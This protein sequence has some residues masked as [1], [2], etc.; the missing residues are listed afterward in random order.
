MKKRDKIFIAGHKGMVGSAIF[1]LLDK[2]GYR[3]II[4]RTRDKLDLLNQ[5]DVQNFF[6]HIKPKFVFV[7]AARVGGLDLG[8]VPGKKG[9]NLEGILHA[10][11]IGKIDAIYLLGADEI[12]MTKLKD[13]FV[14]YQGHH[15][16]I[17]AHHA[18]VILPGS[19]YTEKNA[20]YV[21]TEGRPQRTQVATFPPG[22]AREDWTIIR[23][24][25][26][27]LGK[28]LGY[29]DL[30]E[31]RSRLVEINPIFLNLN[32]IIPAAWGK[33]GD[34]GK[35]NT[36]DFKSPI[37]DFYKTDPISRASYTMSC[38]KEINSNSIIEKTGT[39]D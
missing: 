3:N 18:D 33:F 16:D 31:I 32:E 21:N 10:A 7:A 35:P 39:D 17:G 38:C 19:A 9:L 5:N 26:D 28:S 12:D 6:N 2:R 25:S 24:L 22:D 13:T 23:A 36:L 4:I 20:T 27:V 11:E 14:V 29:N 8:F 37:F 1:R 30:K 34:S 15:G